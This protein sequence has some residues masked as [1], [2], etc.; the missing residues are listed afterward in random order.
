MATLR[1]IASSILCT[2]S[3]SSSGVSF[4]EALSPE[5]AAF[6]VEILNNLWA[7]LT[8]SGV[9]TFYKC[10]LAMDSDI[11]MIAS[12][13]LTVMGMPVLLLDVHYCFDF[14]LSLT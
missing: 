1:L 7:S 2:M 12:N 13:C 5:A 3:L 4:W 10:I 8:C 9:T 11:L 6:N 14:I